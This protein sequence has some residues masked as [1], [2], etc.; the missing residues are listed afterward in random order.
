MSASTHLR[1]NREFAAELKFVVSRGL[2]GQIRD[3]SRA[4][5]SPDPNASSELSD[6]YVIS[7]LYF[8]TDQ[9]AVFHRQG[10]FG[11]SKYR[12][13][14][15]G[16]SEIAFL[17]RKLKTR[18]LVSKRRSTVRIDELA[19]LDG[20][21]PD[22]GWAGYW[23]HQ[24][25]LARRLKPVSQISYRRTARVLMTAFGPVRL[26]LDEDI[27]ALA[28][29]DLTF[30]NADEGLLL[31]EDQVILELKYRA[32]MPGLFKELIETFALAAQPISKYRLAVVALGFVMESISTVATALP[33]QPQTG[34]GD[35]PPGLDFFVANDSRVRQSLALPKVSLPRKPADG[36]SR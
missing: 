27:R 1:E 36:E 15:Y 34:W 5:L 8:D 28:A 29:T 25:L 12:I 2:A 35:P 32:E 6:A 11:R 17:E 22:R 19:H 4:R 31:S 33:G 9:F 20:A 14:R 16:P 13:R 26:T 7:S 30:K 10:S 21:R 24:R 3:W 18:G 23:Y